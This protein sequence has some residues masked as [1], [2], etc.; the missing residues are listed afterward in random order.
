MYRQVRY[1]NLYPG[2]DL[3]CYGLDGGKLEYDLVVA[4]GADPGRIRFR[5][6]AGH[7][8]AIGADGDLHVDG[9]HGSLSIGQPVFYQNVDHGKAAIFRIVRPDQGNGEFGFHA[10]HYDRTLPLVID[11]PVN[12]LYSTYFGGSLDDEAAGM[13]IDS[14]GNSYV[15][16]GTNSVDMLSTSNALQPGRGAPTAGY[17]VTNAFIA[18]FD[19]SGTLLYGTYLGGSNLEWAGAIAVDAQGDAYVTGLSSSSDFP[20]TANAYSAAGAYGNQMFISE[21]SPDGSTLEY[22]TIYGVAGTSSAIVTPANVVVTWGNMGIAVSAQ[23]TIYV[24][25][26]AYSGLPTSLTAY[27]GSLP[28]AAISA[29]QPSSRNSTRRSLAPTSCWRPRISPRPRH[30]P[31]STTATSVTMAPILSRLRSITAA[32][33]GL[34]ERTR[35]ERCPP[36]QGAIKKRHA[37]QPQHHLRT[38]VLLSPRRGLRSSRPT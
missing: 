31:A 36:P 18:K 4:P 22:S 20:T 33:S 2:I 7:T 10:V 6:G 35:P 17:Q 21:I 30:H 13:A 28:S 14:Q 29:M 32:T 34:A 12:I 38:A 8:A 9:D 24:S 11:P 5:F 19:P 23:N 25:S 3:V 1:V 27:M 16:G 26:S 15:A 37:R